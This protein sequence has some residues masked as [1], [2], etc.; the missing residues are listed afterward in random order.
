MKK[1]FGVFRKYRLSD[2]QAAP[3]V[4]ALRGR[5]DAWVDFMMRFELG[6]EPPDPRR[7]MKS[8]LT[9]A[10]AYVAGGFIPL[11]PYLVLGTARAAL[12]ASVLIT[13][14]A[15]LIFGYVKG[16]FTGARPA[17][18]ALQTAL[19]GGLA[20]TAAFLTP[21]RSREGLAPGRTPAPSVMLGLRGH[22]HC[23]G[24]ASPRPREF[25]EA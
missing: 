2:E 6:L 13:V 12:N 7:A 9:I 24:Y 11:A 5:P 3:I 4:E 18:S 23:S 17:R 19:I 21:G 8:A 22:R 20:A 14:V 1:V 10:G 25:D 16:R 15:L